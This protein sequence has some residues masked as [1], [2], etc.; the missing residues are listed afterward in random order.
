MPNTPKPKDVGP[1]SQAAVSLETDFKEV[2]RL[3]SA[4]SEATQSKVINF[5]HAQ[6]LLTKFSEVGL[7]LGEEIQTLAKALDEGRQRAEA[8]TRDV[9]KSAAILQQRQDE[10]NA[11][12]ERFQA[13]G[14]R[15]QEVTASLAPFGHKNGNPADKTETHLPAHLPELEQQLGSLAEDAE[16]LKEE[17]RAAQFKELEREAGAMGQGLRATRQK[18]QKLAASM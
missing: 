13:L 6:K 7:R 18:I 9:A 16:K 8:A 12:S 17:A 3:S 2:E 1:L 10:R 14:K 11:L 15:V 5:D 4:L